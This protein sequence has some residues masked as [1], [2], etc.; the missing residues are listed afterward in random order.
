MDEYVLIEETIYEKE[1]SPQMIDAL[2]KEGVRIYKV[3]SAKDVERAVAQEQRLL[4]GAETRGRELSQDPAVMGHESSRDEAVAGHVCSH[5]AEAGAALVYSSEM[6]AAVAGEGLACAAYSDEGNEE[7]SFDG[8][9]Y[10]VT[11]LE[12]VDADFFRLIRARHFGRPLHIADTERLEIR[13]F[14][15]ADFE[16][17]YAMITSAP[18]GT[19]ESIP[20]D[21]RESCREWFVS[22]IKTKYAFYDYGYWGAFDREGRLVGACGVEVT[23]IP[24]APCV[25][26]DTPEGPDTGACSS[27]EDRKEGLRV[28]ANELGYMVAPDF[29]G[30]GYAVEMVSAVAGFAREKLGFEKL[31]CRVSGDN[32]ASRKTIEAVIE[33]D[34]LSY[35]CSELGGGDLLFLLE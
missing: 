19:V 25:A 23:D 22:Y 10:L 28:P 9:M 34:R 35:S 18:E 14:E 3:A 13:E 21:S 4:S 33:K 20:L 7:A 30:R 6:A 27:S 24:A 32:V 16:V 26:A 12:G 5:A 1:F 8:V 11:S 17:F 2:G 15:E 31:V 29:R